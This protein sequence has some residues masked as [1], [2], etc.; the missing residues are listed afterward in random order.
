MHSD[1]GGGGSASY[2]IEGRDLQFLTRL[3]TAPNPALRYLAIILGRLCRN[4]KQ[5]LG[6][7]TSA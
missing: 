5:T 6:L 1:V 3:L 4:K 2:S 7:A